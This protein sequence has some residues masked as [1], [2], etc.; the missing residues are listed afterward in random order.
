MSAILTRMTAESMISDP[1]SEPTIDVH[2]DQIQALATC[3]KAA[4][5]TLR[6]H[7][8]AILASDSF[9]VLELCQVF[10]TKQSGMSHHLKVLSRAELVCT[11]REGNT[12][13]YRR[14]DTQVSA[15]LDSLRN[16]IY[17]SA[18]ALPLTAQLE[19]NLSKIYALRAAASKN[20]FHTHSTQFKQQQDLIASF[21]VYGPEV[22]KLLSVSAKSTHLR[23]LEIGPG[24]GEFLPE[25]SHRYAHVVALDTSEKMLDQGRKHCESFN[26][27]NIEFVCGDTS[28]CHSRIEEFDCAVINMVLHHTPSPKQ[29]FQDAA[30]ALR[31]EGVLLVCD[32]G[33]HNQDWVRQACGD[34]W[35]GFSSD[36]LKNWADKA[37][38]TSKSS[39]FFAL[40]NGFQIQIHQFIKKTL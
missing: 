39:R 18:E 13:F 27:S 25:L 29:I 30:A 24:I 23:A 21:D 34:Q 14:S 9:G 35:L 4:G 1:V 15:E 12:I 16:A 11:R 28:V 37:K 38:L 26:L 2:D 8:L 31:E 7:V 6:L 10:D 5:D 40:R 22:A 32:L 36:D 19:N 17:A 20:F 33:A 3:L